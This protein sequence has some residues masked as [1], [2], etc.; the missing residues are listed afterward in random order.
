MDEI[1][2][3][4]KGKANS[5]MERGNTEIQVQRM[6]LSSTAQDRG[7]RRSMGETFV[8]QRRLLMSIM[9]NLAFHLISI[10]LEALKV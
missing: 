9:C 6:D 10:Y 2:V 4:K 1:G 5:P 8:L 3:Y 7:R